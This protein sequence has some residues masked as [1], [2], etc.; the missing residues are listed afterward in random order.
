MINIK[1]TNRDIIKINGLLYIH[2][3]N[4]YNKTHSL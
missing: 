3:M 1:K 4:F 2:S